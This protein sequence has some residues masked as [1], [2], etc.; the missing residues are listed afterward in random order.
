MVESFG[1]EL[2]TCTSKNQRI[3]C[4]SIKR[5]FRGYTRDNGDCKFL[6][7]IKTNY[8]CGFPKAPMLPRIGLGLASNNDVDN[9]EMEAIKRKTLLTF[10][11]T[12][13]IYNS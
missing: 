9:I 1:V 12:S 2:A 11:K 3:A 8:M 10:E 6:E 7:E 13:M 5:L 4:Y